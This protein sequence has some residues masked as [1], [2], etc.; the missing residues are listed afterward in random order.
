[1]AVIKRVLYD[2]KDERSTIHARPNRIIIRKD[3]RNGDKYTL[4]YRRTRVKHGDITTQ[5]HVIIYVG[6]FAA[7]DAYRKGKTLERVTG[8]GTIKCLLSIRRQLES[9]VER[10]KWN[11]EL[12]MRWADEKRHRAYKRLTKMP[13]F[14]EDETA[15]VARNPKIWLWEG[16]Q[17]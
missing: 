1:M 14:I 2:D 4:E 16:E 11:E 8:N 5:W 7:A 9:F 13:G 10:M 3:L 6:D 17:R 15:Y 12:V